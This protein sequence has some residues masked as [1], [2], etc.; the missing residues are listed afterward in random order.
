MLPELGLE[1]W[2]SCFSCKQAD[3]CTIQNQ[4]S[5]KVNK[6]HSF[7]CVTQPTLQSVSHR[8]STCS[9]FIIWFHAQFCSWNIE[10][11]TT[12]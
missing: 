1:A 3:Q 10:L 11:N 12:K 9:S 8:Q 2:I 6:P 4:E 5:G 7:C